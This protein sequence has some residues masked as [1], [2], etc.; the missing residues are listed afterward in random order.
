MDVKVIIEQS[1]TVNA[2]L[3]S[4]V[5]EKHFWY[6]MAVNNAFPYELLNILGTNY[7]EWLYLNLFCEVL[8]SNY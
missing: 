7:G 6:A 3:H 2:K 5:K 4:I 1:E 8:N